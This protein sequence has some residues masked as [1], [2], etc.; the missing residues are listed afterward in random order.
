MTRRLL[1]CAIAILPV[2]A[3]ACGRDAPS[4]A[5]D[6]G[7]PAQTAQAAAPVMVSAKPSASAQTKAAPLSASD[8]KTVLK[9]LEE[10][11][12]NARAKDFDGAISAFK[13][14]LALTPDDARVLAE[15]GWAA[16]N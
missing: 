14:A 1:S 16:L 6:A 8:R 9:A 2:L 5:P 13:R 4:S 11:R 10:G 7:S 3:V 15:L 12:K